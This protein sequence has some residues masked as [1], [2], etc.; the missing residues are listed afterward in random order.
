MT[1]QKI[2]ELSIIK[3]EEIQNKIKN[4]KEIYNIEITD[5][6]LEKFIKFSLN[7]IDYYNKKY[8]C[9]EGDE[10]SQLYLF[11]IKQSNYYHYNILNVALYNDSEYIPFKNKL[12]L[13]DDLLYNF[14]IILGDII[15]DQISIK[16]NKNTYVNLLNNNNINDIKIENFKNIKL[17]YQEKTLLVSYIY[18]Y[19]KDQ[20]KIIEAIK[21][22]LINFKNHFTLL[23]EFLFNYNNIY[24]KTNSNIELYF[25]SMIS[26]NNIVE[27]NIENHKNILKYLEDYGL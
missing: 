16:T 2:K 25:E 10:Y 27:K 9:F 23:E 15:C 21:K 24:L 26:L 14:Y 7:A 12:N 13:N 11:Y 1:L 20:N 5:E 3:T 22:E 6:L 17:P 19:N 4:I 18:Y 8:N